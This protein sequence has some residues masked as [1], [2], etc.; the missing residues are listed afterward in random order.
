MHD[1][2]LELKNK[3][4]SGSVHANLIIDG[5]DT[6]V[7][8]LSSEEL[9]TMIRVLGSGAQKLQDVSFRT[10]DTISNREEEFDYDVFD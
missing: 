9:E 5:Q 4:T 2:K 3:T 7:L 8:Y 6:G 10:S 1:V